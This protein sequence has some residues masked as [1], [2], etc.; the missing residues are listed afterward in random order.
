MQADKAQQQA[1]AEQDRLEDV[2][3]GIRSEVE[4]A[5]KGKHDAMQQLFLEEQRAKTEQDWLK[6]IAAGIRSKL[7]HAETEAHD[8]L[9]RL[10]SELEHAE[11]QRVKS[12]LNGKEVS[13]K[14][15]QEQHRAK[16][17]KGRLE[18]LVAALR[19]EIAHM[20]SQAESQHAAILEECDEKLRIVEARATKFAAKEATERL[21]RQGLAGEMRELREAHECGAAPGSDIPASSPERHD[22]SAEVAASTVQV[23]KAELQEAQ[24]QSEYFQAELAR[25]RSQAKNQEVR[26]QLRQVTAGCEDQVTAGCEDG[27]LRTASETAHSIALVDQLDARMARACLSRGKCC[28]M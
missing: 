5:E 13:I 6:G 11:Q 24:L 19:T 16:E 18:E 28:I 8:S 10:R 26:Q 2:A 1:Q 17:E 12:K 20:E 14:A 22:L 15:A 27:L 25:E 3:A 23:L 21:L 7:E 9:K 4:D